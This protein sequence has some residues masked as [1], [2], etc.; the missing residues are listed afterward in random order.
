MDRSTPPPRP[1]PECGAPMECGFLVD[2]TQGGRIP[3]QWAEGVP[4]R[5]IWTGTSLRGR[6]VYEVESWRCAECG[7]LR[8][9]A[10]ER[11]R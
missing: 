11:K 1:C 9:Y 6:A 2:A 10:I 5:S 4:K 3:T 8:S 7:A